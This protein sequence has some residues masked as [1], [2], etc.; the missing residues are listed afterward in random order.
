MQT[1]P[2]WPLKILQLD[3]GVNMIIKIENNTISKKDLGSCM[4]WI[5]ISAWGN[6]LLWTLQNP[7]NC[8]VAPKIE[9]IRLPASPT[10][11][12]KGITSS[13]FKNALLV[14]LFVKR[15]GKTNASPMTVP[16]AA[17][18][19]RPP[20]VTP[21][22]VPL[23]T[24]CQSITKEIRMHQSNTYFFVQSRQYETSFDYVKAKSEI[25]YFL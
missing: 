15:P 25:G 12:E 6:T 2:F 1:R 9:S 16:A 4:H 24:C 19:W 3:D 23:W 11:A 14:Q 21:P 8:S 17:A 10:V 13:C 20:T 7:L 18:T 5:Y 22:F